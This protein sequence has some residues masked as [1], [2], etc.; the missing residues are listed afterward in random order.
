MNPCCRKKGSP[1][2]FGNLLQN[3]GQ[4]KREFIGA[5]HKV[6]V[7]GKAFLSEERRPG[8]GHSLQD[9]YSDHS[10]FS[11][12]PEVGYGFFCPFIFKN[13]K[14]KIMRS[15]SFRLLHFDR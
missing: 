12:Q 5:R 8:S 11:K 4:R 13:K 6:S 1:L 7:F 14:I 9:L 15:C 10:G 2:T 3:P